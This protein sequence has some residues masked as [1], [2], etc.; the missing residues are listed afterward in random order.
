MKGCRA[1]C[2]SR[3]NPP[4][5]YLP[6]PDPPHPSPHPALAPSWGNHLQHS[7]LCTVGTNSRPVKRPNTRTAFG[8]LEFP[9]MTL[10][11]FPREENPEQSPPTGL[12]VVSWPVEIFSKSPS[13]RC[14]RCQEEYRPRWAS[15]CPTSLPRALPSLFP[16][17]GG[18][19]FSGKGR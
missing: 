6:P 2:L 15:T 4:P 8:F 16:L 18:G 7:A 9:S 11:S 5:T 1:C 10:L 17:G 3:S 14:A 19:L 12:S 13:K